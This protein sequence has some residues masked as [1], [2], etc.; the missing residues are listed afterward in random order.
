ML[1]NDQP[2]GTYKMDVERLGVTGRREYQGNILIT[3]ETPEGPY[4]LQ[5]FRGN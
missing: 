3:I 1:K 4:E 5:R 2:F